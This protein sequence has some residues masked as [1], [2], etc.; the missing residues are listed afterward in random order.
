MRP[1]P[2]PPPP[3]LP[4]LA[5]PLPASQPRFSADR[6]RSFC[7]FLDRLG[8]L[9]SCA[10]GAVRDLFPGGGRDALARSPHGTCHPSASH[11]SPALTVLGCL[12][13][14]RGLPVPWVG[15]CTRPPS[16]PR[17]STQLLSGYLAVLSR[18]G[19][20]KPRGVGRPTA[21]WSSVGGLPS[22]SPHLVLP[23]TQRAPSGRRRL[24]R[25]WSGGRVA[26]PL[27][28][29]VGSLPE[30]P[31]CPPIGRPPLCAGFAASHVPCVPPFRSR[32]CLFFSLHM[33]PLVSRWL[34]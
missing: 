25:R 9:I 6:G 22:S 33:Y 34:A 29:P 27:W 19:G 31:T 21:R 3:L 24:Q 11:S 4:P 20:L 7:L 18:C 13:P 26:S 28:A 16:G 10:P 23:Q 15:S 14:V 32:P 17:L 30:H 2:P 12:C 5:P 8:N 1:P